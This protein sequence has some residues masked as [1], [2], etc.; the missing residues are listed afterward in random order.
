MS[1]PN[2][3]HP[4][5][6]REHLAQQSTFAPDAETLAA[7]QQLVAVLDRHRP[8]GPNGKHGGLHTLTCGCEGTLR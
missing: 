6:L 5:G 3:W 4:K 8:L 2:R 7:I 1:Y